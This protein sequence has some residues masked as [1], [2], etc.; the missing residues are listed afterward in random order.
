MAPCHHGVCRSADACCIS[1]LHVPEVYTEQKAAE[2][3]LGALQ[4]P[5]CAAKSLRGPRTSQHRLPN[6]LIHHQLQCRAGK[7]VWAVGGGLVVAPPLRSS[8]STCLRRILSQQLALHILQVN[9]KV[10]N[11]RNTRVQAA[12]LSRRCSRQLRAMRSRRRRSATCLCPSL[13]WSACWR[14]AP[15]QALLGCSTT[16]TCWTVSAEAP[17]VAHNLL[18]VAFPLPLKLHCRDVCK[19]SRLHKGMLLRPGCGRQDAAAFV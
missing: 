2:M 4:R 5:L 8:A 1:I 9:P 12:R 15:Q 18:I 7:S 13:L 11:L 19:A 14:T 6:R 17:C 10:L 16:Q 3:Q